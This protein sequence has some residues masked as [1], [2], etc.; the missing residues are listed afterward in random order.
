MLLIHVPYFA[1]KKTFGGTTLVPALV[2][3]SSRYFT[4]IADDQAI[5]QDGDRHSAHI[6]CL[7][8]RLLNDAEVSKHD[9][10]RQSPS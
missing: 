4:R 3:Y 2:I 9:I 8:K 5:K 1:R 6:S 7:T 10:L